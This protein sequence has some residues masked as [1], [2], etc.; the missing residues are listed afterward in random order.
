MQLELLQ[1]FENMIINFER[2][3]EI[4]NE[5]FFVNAVV[6]KAKMLKF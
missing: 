3:V 5:V 4:N 6:T 1:Y 2:V